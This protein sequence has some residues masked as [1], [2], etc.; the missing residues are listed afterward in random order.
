MSNKKMGK[1]I[2]ITGGT[3]SIGFEICKALAD[4]A[5]YSRVILYSRDWHKQKNAKAILQNSK[6]RY[7]LG[8]VCDYNRLKLAMRGVDEV[9]HTAALKDVH[10]AE[11]NPSE[12]IRVNCTGTQNL[13]DAALDAQVKKTIIISSDKAVNPINIYGA[14]KCVAEK[15]TLNYNTYAAGNNIKFAVVR[16]GNV[17]DSQG[18][19]L[20]EWLKPE[21]TELELY[22]DKCTRF[23]LTKNKTIQFIFDVIK[24]LDYETWNY[25]SFEY[26]YI[27]EMKA[28]KVKDLIEIIGKPYRITSLSWSEK[29]HEYITPYA[30]S[31]DADMMTTDEIAYQIVHDTDLEIPDD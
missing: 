14:S 6:Y 1:S 12:A 20:R 2:L 15:M 3:G 27:P 5:D 13:L 26:L 10:F 11:S 29:L 28:F 30:A 25:G 4:N 18:A 23:W 21:N 7:F 17:I 8:D 19:V 9:I 22:N 16:L 31:C 24:R